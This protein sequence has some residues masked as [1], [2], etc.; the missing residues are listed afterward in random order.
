MMAGK[1]PLVLKPFNPL[2]GMTWPVE[3]IVDT[4]G[5]STARMLGRA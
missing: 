4:K 3:I 5:L 1:Y 2:S